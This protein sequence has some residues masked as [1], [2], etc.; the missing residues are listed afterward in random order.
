MIDFLFGG[1]IRFARAAYYE[2]LVILQQQHAAML[3]HLVMNTGGASSPHMELFKASKLRL[4]G[5]V[6]LADEARAKL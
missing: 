5:L 4:S 1:P 2:S 6:K 3:Y